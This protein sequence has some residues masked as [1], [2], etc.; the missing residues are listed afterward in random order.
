MNTINKKLYE[1]AERFERNTNKDKWI[2]FQEIIKNSDLEVKKCT[3]YEIFIQ[4]TK[5]SMSD[6]EIFPIFNDNDGFVHVQ[7]WNYDFKNIGYKEKYEHLLKVN[8]HVHYSMPETIRFL[9]NLIQDVK[10]DINYSTDN[11]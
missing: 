6:I 1:K 10:N 4:I 2:A 5:E 8:G 3:D 11:R 9:N 7:L